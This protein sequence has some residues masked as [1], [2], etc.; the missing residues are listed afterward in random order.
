[1]I[2]VME[3]GAMNMGRA[4][5]R[6]VGNTG[7]KEREELVDADWEDLKKGETGQIFPKRLRIQQQANSQADL[8]P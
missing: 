3:R 6:R 8:S 2:E 5:K 4:L 1:M 7:Y